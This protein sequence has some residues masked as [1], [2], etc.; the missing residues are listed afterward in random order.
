LAEATVPA[1]SVTLQVCP[2]GCV[3][4]VTLYGEPLDTDA[5]NANTPSLAIVKSLPPLFWSTSPLPVSPVT[6]TLTMNSVGA[7]VHAT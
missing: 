5:L 7:V 1:P 3:C 6:E 4:T 2:V